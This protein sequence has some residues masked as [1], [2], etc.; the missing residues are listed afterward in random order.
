M[1]QNDMPIPDIHMEGGVGQGFGDDPIQL[2]HVAFCQ[3]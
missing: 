1:G 2:D 3:A